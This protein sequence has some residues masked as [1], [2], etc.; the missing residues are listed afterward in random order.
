[1]SAVLGFIRGGDFS[2]TYLEIALDDVRKGEYR[3]SKLRG[4]LSEGLKT[5][6]DEFDKWINN[7]DSFWYGLRNEYQN[8]VDLLKSGEKV[9]IYGTTIP[10]E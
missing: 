7:G 3:M 1:M 2:S 6:I 9:T 5:K 10:G 4:A 8:H